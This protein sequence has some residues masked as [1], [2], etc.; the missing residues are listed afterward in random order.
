LDGNSVHELEGR[1]IQVMN[2][3]SSEERQD[4]PNHSNLVYTNQGYL[5]E[6]DNREMIRHRIP[7]PAHYPRP[8]YHPSTLLGSIHSSD[9]SYQM[10]EV[11]SRR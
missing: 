10:G 7:H 3:T 5:V 6:F 2:N 4:F 9:P 1:P 8:N 11:E